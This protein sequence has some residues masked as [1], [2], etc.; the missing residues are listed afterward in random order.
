M[1]LQLV[2]QIA[3]LVSVVVGFT[4]LINTIR[5][6]R[7]QMTVQIL[8]K[9]TERYE[10]IIA[11][12]PRNA[13]IHRFDLSALPATD[14]ETTMS[15]LRYLNLCSEEYYLY[16]NGY[17]SKDLWAI[18]EMELKRMLSSALVRRE[19]ASVRDEFENHRS[20]LE[21][22]NNVHSRRPLSESLSRTVAR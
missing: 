13:L 11:S 18:W 5:S 22:V 4:S 20:F 7:R 17:L 1:N 19:W 16:E 9:Y 14:A 21:Y 3:T 8:M 6:A 15:V 2:I 10:A 12:F